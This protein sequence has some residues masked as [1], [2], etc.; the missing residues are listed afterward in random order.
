MLLGNGVKHSFFPQSPIPSSSQDSEEKKCEDGGSVKVHVDS[1]DHAHRHACGLPVRK[2]FS[3]LTDDES[4][5]VSDVFV[6][7]W[8]Q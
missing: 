2:Q 1:Y 3:T 6:A 4:I 5:A 8:Q 7:S